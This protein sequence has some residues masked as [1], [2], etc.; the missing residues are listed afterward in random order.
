MLGD[1]I[2]EKKSQGEA[3][4]TLEVVDVSQLLLRSV[5]G[6]APK[7]EAETADAQG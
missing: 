7:E 3:K 2:N 5:R 4:E 1:A 6:E